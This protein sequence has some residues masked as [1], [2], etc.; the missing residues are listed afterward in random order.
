MRYGKTDD[1][2]E[3]S[4]ILGVIGVS[5]GG[6][7]LWKRLFSAV[8]TVLVITMWI[9]SPGAVAYAA[10]DDSSSSDQGQAT[11]SQ[12]ITDPYN[13]LGSNLTKVTDAISSTYDSTGVSVKLSYMLHFE[14]VEDP[15][16]WA[17]EALDATNPKPNTVLLAVAL[18]DGK[19]VVAVS[20]N[21]ESWLYNKTTSDQLLKSAYGPVSGRNPDW[22]GS[23]IAMMDSIATIKTTTAQRGTVWK[24][25]G[26]SVMC[27][28]LVVLIVIGVV[29]V[30]RRRRDTKGKQPDAEKDAGK[31]TEKATKKDTGKSAEKRRSKGDAAESDSPAEDD[32]GPKSAS[33]ESDGQSAPSVPM[34][35]RERREASRRGK[36]F[37][38]SS[39]A[40]APKPGNTDEAA[41]EGS[42]ER[43]DAWLASIVPQD[44]DG[45]QETSRTS[46]QAGN[47]EQAD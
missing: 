28:V 16:Q 41:D 36:R 45:V 10:G 12:D 25:V 9:T 13:V 3:G 7:S 31:S 20:G 33:S 19:L 34:T 43:F 39:A 1:V 5:R 17:Q 35:R 38:T 47:H 14:G 30:V 15:D 11:F 23:A 37:G 18:N 4:A 40:T 2:V 46:S 8:L 24:W 29:T 27:G 42:R 21:S 22:S 26:I 32:G 44:T 6:F